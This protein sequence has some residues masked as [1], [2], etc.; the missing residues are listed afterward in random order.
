[1]IIF[2]SFIIFFLKQ[3]NSGHISSWDLVLNYNN[4]GYATEFSLSF[5]LE[6]GLTSNEYI[7]LIFP[8]LLHSKVVNNIPIDVSASMLQNL[9]GYNCGSL[10]PSKALIYYISNA[11]YIQFLDNKSLLSNTFYTIIVKIGQA[12]ANLQ[13]SGVKNPIQVKINFFKIKTKIIVDVFCI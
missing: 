5:S 1:M 6:S 11:Y 10:T 4:A 12:N 13:S 9:D 3:I 2:F 7:K 8:F